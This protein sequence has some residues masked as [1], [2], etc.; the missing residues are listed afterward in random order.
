MI[1]ALFCKCQLWILFLEFFECS[2][3]CALDQMIS[4]IAFPLNL[5]LYSLSWSLSFHSLLQSISRAWDVFAANQINNAVFGI[6]WFDLRACIGI[7]IEVLQKY[8][9]NL[10]RVKESIIISL[11][12]W[13][14]FLL[15]TWS[16]LDARQYWFQ[17]PLAI[18]TVNLWG[19]LIDIIHR[20]LLRNEYFQ[21]FI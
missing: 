8:F 15:F 17:W 3:Y 1:S 6:F 9:L 11:N 18:F 21:A 12:K 4:F 14:A 7:G 20:L 16:S 2:F 19:I 13:L 10:W 5:G